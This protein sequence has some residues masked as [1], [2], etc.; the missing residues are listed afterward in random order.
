[1]S[2]GL[3]GSKANGKPTMDS[4]VGVLRVLQQEEKV[5]LVAKTV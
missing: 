5:R 1:M 2:T 3:K 4:I